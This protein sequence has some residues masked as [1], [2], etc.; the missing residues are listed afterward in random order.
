VIKWQLTRKYLKYTFHSLFNLL[1]LTLPLK[2]LVAVSSPSEYVPNK[3]QLFDVSSMGVR[4][5]SSFIS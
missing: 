2:K 1:I 4:R 3:G 5:I